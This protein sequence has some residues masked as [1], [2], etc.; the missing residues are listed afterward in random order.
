MI[1]VL[2]A[3]DHTLIRDSLKLLLTLEEDIEVVAEVGRGDEVVLAA[4]ATHP[5]VALL[6]VEMPGCD[7]I[8]A[9]AD[10]HVQCPSC[11]VLILTTFWH[12]DHEKRV[13]E[14]GI[15]GVLLKGTSMAQVA[16]TIRRVVA[17]GQDA[18]D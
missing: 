18:K 12:P 2:L 3:E 9:A 16:G 7:G 13:A 8:T 17:S 6:D 15:A 10:L 4:L 1:R 11:C 14:S 5:D